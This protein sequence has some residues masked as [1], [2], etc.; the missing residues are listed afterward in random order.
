M[1]AVEDVTLH[2]R[3]VGDACT[4]QLLLVLWNGDA[5]PRSIR[6][7]RLTTCLG[8]DVRVVCLPNFDSLP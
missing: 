2:D 5:L 1:S 3:L 4:K 8:T 7:A 6:R